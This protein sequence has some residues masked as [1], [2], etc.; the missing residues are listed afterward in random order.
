MLKN[1]GLGNILL[2]DGCSSY[3]EKV[4]EGLALSVYWRVLPL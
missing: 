4:C 3:I 2:S 1:G